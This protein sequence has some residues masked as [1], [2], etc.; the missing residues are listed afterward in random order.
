MKA[1]EIIDRL[2]TID[3]SYKREGLEG[4]K[5]NQLRSMLA[6]RERRAEEGTPEGASTP[7]ADSASEGASTPEV[8]TVDCPTFGQG[9]DPEADHCKDCNSRFGEGT[10]EACKAASVEVPV[11]KSKGTGRASNV[12]RRERKPSDLVKRGKSKT[13]EELQAFLNKP[14]GRI[15]RITDRLIAQG[16][17]TMLEIID[18]T[19][20]YRDEEAPGSNWLSNAKGSKSQVGVLKN[21]LGYRAKEQGWV[22]RISPE[23]KVFVD[24]TVEGPGSFTIEPPKEVKAEEPEAEKAAA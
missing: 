13:A 11:T 12:K 19:N 9:H 5:Y 7:E 15:T 24:G 22:V 10:V 23:G 4:L 1:N 3:N 18:M 6:E 2:L 20:L 21:H 14:T 8:K 17:L 16:G